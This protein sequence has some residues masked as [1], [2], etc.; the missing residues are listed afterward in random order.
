MKLFLARLPT[1]NPSSFP[2]GNRKTQIITAVS[3]T[4]IGTVKESYEFRVREKYAGRLFG[5]S[6]GKKLG[7]SKLFGDKFV[8]IRKIELSSDDP[9]LKRV[10]ELNS[11]LWREHHDLFF[12]GWD[13]H[14]RYTADELAKAELLLLHHISTFE[15][16]GEER[17]TQ[18]DE[19]SA[20]KHCKAGARQLS[21]LFLDWNR[22][23]KGKDIARTIAGEIVVSQRVVKLFEQHSISGAECRPIRHRPASSAESQDWFQLVVESCDAH[24]VPPTKTGIKPFDEDITGEY[25]CPLGD[26]IGLARMSELWISRPSYSGSDIVATSQ[27][28]GTRRGLL[29]P[30]RFLLI[31]PKLQRVI[32][33]Q[34]L[35][36]FKLEVVH[37]V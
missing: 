22:I 28:I 2:P 1:T 6:E 31:S 20:C 35:R 21:P 10:G 26:L 15:P 19:S 3:V 37:L 24:V 7:W 32:E 5:P 4:Q 13:I 25:R 12:A 11:S 8:M 33:R 30:E 27:F 23:P 36:G 16:A 29:R 18:Y 14:R 9:K 17:G 34:R